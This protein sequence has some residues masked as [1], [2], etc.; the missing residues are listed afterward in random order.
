MGVGKVR[1]WCHTLAFVLALVLAIYVIL[2]FE[3]P[4]VG[5]IRIDSIDQCSGPTGEHETINLPGRGH[6]PRSPSKAPGP[7]NAS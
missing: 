6:S 1:H 7:T 2:G 3:F 4:A 5:L